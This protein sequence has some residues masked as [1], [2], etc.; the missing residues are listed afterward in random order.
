L[1]FRQN[2]NVDCI[3]QESLI[4]FVKFCQNLIFT[5]GGKTNEIN[6][7]F[8]ENMPIRISSSSIVAI[9]KIFPNHA[10]G[11]DGV[12]IAVLRKGR[13]GF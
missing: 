4:T 7:Q 1:N 13:A 6:K 5:N 9:S 8:L 12:K 2:E 11:A 3:L 10:T